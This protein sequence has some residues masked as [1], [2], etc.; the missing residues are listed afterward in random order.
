[1]TD[2][3]LN[4]IRIRYNLTE[5][6]PTKIRY[7]LNQIRGKLHPD[8]NGGKFPSKDKEVEYFEIDNLIKQIDEKY[9]QSLVPFSHIREIIQD[10]RSKL[11]EN[12]QKINS[13][14]IISSE[15]TN[16]RKNLSE[17]TTST[18]DQI[19]YSNIAPKISISGVTAILTIIW[20]FPVTIQSHPILSMFI[21]VTT[22]L[23]LIIWIFSLYFT[24]IFWIF[25][26]RIETCEKEILK[27]L[28]DEFFQDNL[29]VRFIAERGLF[30]DD[31]S[32]RDKFTKADL[33][34]YVYYAI[35]CVAKKSK[36]TVYSSNIDEMLDIVQFSGISLTKLKSDTRFFLGRINLKY[37]RSCDQNGMSV[38]KQI[39]IQN[40]DKSLD[41]QTVQNFANVILA[42]AEGKR[43]IERQTPP[44]YDDEYSIKLKI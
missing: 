7:E 28:N 41:P 11:I 30:K 19:K 34:S 38:L 15:L 21:D 18:I 42:R 25:I 1:M 33:I 8:K 17:R 44:L 14:L 20:F 3:F 32:S 4:K 37:V 26:L 5:E 39:L 31:N 43:F 22:P 10:D 40:L 9:I 27:L 16:N 35:Y 2:E 12:I 36:I 6:D 13:D 23:F 24:L 29:I